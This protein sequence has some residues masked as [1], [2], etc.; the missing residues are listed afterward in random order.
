MLALLLALLLAGQGAGAAEPA[1]VQAAWPGRALLRT[2]LPRE[3]GGEAQNWALAQGADGVLHAGNNSGVL[4]YDG[5]RWQLLPLPNRDVVRS[6]AVDAAGTLWIG[7]KGD[8][9]R[10]VRGADGEARFES[11]LGLV[12]P[13]DRDFKDVWSTFVAGDGVAFVARRQLFL[14]RNGKLAVVRSEHNLIGARWV[15]GRVHVHLWEVGP[16]TLEGERFEPLPGTRELARKGV[17]FV[18]PLDAERLLLA[19]YDDGFYV[20]DGRQA[21]RWPTAA[22]GLFRRFAPNDGKVLADGSLAIGTRGGGLVVLDR[23]GALLRVVDGAAGLPSAHVRNVLQDRQGGVWLALQRGVARVEPGPAFSV[24]DEA[25]GLQ[26]G[27]R[28]LLRHGDTLYVS[29]ATRLFRLRNG[30]LAVVRGLQ[31]ESWGLLF[32]HGRVLAGS[33]LGAFEVEGDEARPVAAEVTRSVFHLHPTDGDPD[34][35]L[36]GLGRGLDRLVWKGGRWTWGHPIEGFGGE[37]R[38]LATTSD[39]WLWIHALP[40]TLARARLRGDALTDLE[41]FGLADGLPAGATHVFDLPGGPVFANEIE[42]GSLVFDGARRRFV[43]AVELSRRYGLPSDR[44]VPL[45]PPDADGRF[46]VR[47]AA[48]VR[49]GWRVAVVTPDARGAFSARVLVDDPLSNLDLRSTALLDGPLLWLGGQDGLVR[50]DLRAIGGDEMPGFATLLRR[51][52]AGPRPLPLAGAEPVIPHAEADLRFE[53]GAPRFGDEAG[54]QFQFRLDGHDAGWSEWVPEGRI[55]YSRLPEGRYTWRARA[56][57]LGHR[58]SAEASYRFR[59]LPPWQRTPWAY[60]AYGLALLATAWGLHSAR[61]RR[62]ERQRAALEAVVAQ[63]TAEVVAQKVEIEAQHQ[64]IQA[65]IRYAERIQRATLPEPAAIG[66][67]LGE[68]AVLYRPRDVVSGDFY[69]SAE[70]PPHRFLALADCT[71]HGVPGALLAMLGQASLDDLVLQQGLVEPEDVLAGLE[72]RLVH[73]LHQRSRDEAVRDGMEVGLLRLEAPQDGVRQVVFA[74][75]GV[76]LLIVQEGTVRKLRGRAGRPLREAL[77]VRPGD[78]LCLASD[79]Y[80]DQLDEQDRRFGSRRFEDLA[81]SLAELPAGA[82]HAALVAALDAHRAGR[83]QLDDV[84]VLVL[85]V[86]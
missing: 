27:V 61:V 19:T 25:S 12:P 20:H 82:R 75:S 39:G 55:S 40:A 54:V 46:V 64:S 80:I 10:L 16:A 65:A 71:G 43:P 76:P 44:I 21:V 14:Y 77:T 5:R 41:T 26:G 29:T 74:S 70:R 53:V 79:G 9:G 48:E 30:Q 81:R 11:L 47:V 45:S 3:Y 22:D 83:D 60:G 58:L 38:G 15:A 28:A 73:A 34:T 69:W 24:F 31:A 59:V 6:L 42:E 13:E 68:A 35:V 4:S 2:Y 8:F 62:L 23:Q 49:D 67:G 78:L 18:L 56:R 66:D 7:G 72:R 51:V 17:M 63:R 32:A 37:V 57:D 84:T 85:E 33:P 36:A 1:A 50:C 52:A 86:G